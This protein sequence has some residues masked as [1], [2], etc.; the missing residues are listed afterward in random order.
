M[1][2][3]RHPH[4]ELTGEYELAELD[5]FVLDG[6]HTIRTGLVRIAMG[7]RS[8]LLGLHASADHEIGYVVS[9]KVQIE[10]A[11][12]IFTASQGDTLIANPDIPHATTA[13]EDTVI[14]FSLAHKEQRL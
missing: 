14:F 2:M 3:R 8:P 7:R 13:L 5:T 12:G 1:S 10:T 4:S 6:R 11:H 9:G